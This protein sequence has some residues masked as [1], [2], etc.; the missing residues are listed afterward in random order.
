[1]GIGPLPREHGRY[2]LSPE[3]LDCRQDAQLVIDDHVMVGRIAPLDIIQGFFLMDIDQHMSIHSIGQTCAFDFA[4][5]EDDI[6]VG[7]DDSWS[8]A[9]QP[10]QYRDGAGEQLLRERIIHEKGGH[11]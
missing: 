4:G 10:L 1:M 6:A 8:K 2:A 9:A 3:T 11:R 7:Q 5:L